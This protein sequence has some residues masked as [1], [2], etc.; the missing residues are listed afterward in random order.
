M[1]WDGITLPAYTAGNPAHI[2]FVL[3]ANSRRF[4][5][6]FRLSRTNFTIGD[7]RLDSPSAYAHRIAVH[8]LPC[9]TLLSAKRSSREVSGTNASLRSATPSFAWYFGTTLQ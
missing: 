2:V 9:R 6:L 5:F 3:V 7:N 4:F 8:S 1:G